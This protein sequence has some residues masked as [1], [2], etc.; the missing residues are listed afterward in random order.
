M[1]L[2]RGE[3]KTD[4]EIIARHAKDGIAMGAVN[5]RVYAFEDFARHHAQSVRDALKADPATRG[6][7]RVALGQSGWRRMIVK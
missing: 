4:A 7:I 5:G 2:K 3:L 6:R 1:E